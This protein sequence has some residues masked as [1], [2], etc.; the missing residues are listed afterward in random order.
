MAVDVL[1]VVGMLGRGWP[2]S[3]AVVLVKV[4]HCWWWE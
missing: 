1:V 2:V 4:G 3:F